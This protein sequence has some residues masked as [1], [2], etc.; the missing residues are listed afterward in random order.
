MRMLELLLCALATTSAGT[1]SAQMAP[2]EPSLPRHVQLGV[3]L[4]PVPDSLRAR[5]IPAGALVT[6]IIQGSSAERAGLAAGDII[7]GIDADSVGSVQD[8]LLV[9]RRLR[10][11]ATVTMR[12]VRK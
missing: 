7:T 1:A 5:G 9:I 6:A 8:A 11:G 4:A 2:T 10:A 3:S 12:T